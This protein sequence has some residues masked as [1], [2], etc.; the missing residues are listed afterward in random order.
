LSSWAT[1][2]LNDIFSV[3]STLTFFSLN[4]WRFLTAPLA[5]LSMF[6]VLLIMTFYLVKTLGPK[7]HLKGTAL[8]M[9]EFFVKGSFYVFVMSIFSLPFGPHG[10]YVCG[11]MPLNVA[12][13]CVQLMQNP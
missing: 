2:S 13:L 11:L 9:V 12:D 8:A 6:D 3:N 4:L 10:S 5:T 7:E 1:S